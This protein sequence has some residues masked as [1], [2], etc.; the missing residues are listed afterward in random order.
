MELVLNLDF[1]D[2]VA[3]DAVPGRARIGCPKGYY[4]EEH[5]V[6]MIRQAAESGFSIINFRIAVCG[7]AF[8]RSRV[9]DW[10]SEPR[11]AWTLHRYD[12]FETAVRA[13][14]EAGVKCYAWITPF[15]DMGVGQQSYFSAQHPKCQLLSREGDD[16]LWGVYCFGFPEVREYFIEHVQELLAY[17]ADGIF[18]SDRSHSNMNHR[19]VEYGFNE[20]VIAAYRQR[21][22]GDPREPDAYDLEKFSRVQGAFYTRFLREAAEHIHKAGARSMAKVSWQRN[23]RIAGRLGALDKSFFEWETWGR[24]GIVDELVIGGDAATGRDPEHILSYMETEADSCNPAYFRKKLPDSVDIHRWVTVWAWGARTP[25]E[26]TGPPNAGF[27]DDVLL[28]G[29]GKFQDTGL[30]G[31]LI[32]EAVTI[33]AHDQW[34]TYR[35]FAE[36]DAADAAD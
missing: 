33:D 11:C 31:A 12:P 6:G 28:A 25:D 21:C 16:P 7:Q 2:F 18:F 29:L 30:A 14:H 17:G 13:S 3:V 24:E 35:Q 22:G 5:L 32:H 1:Y 26:T 4:P 36:S 23:G 20:P 9:K 34:A 8:C 27:N 15:D 10:A 19:Q